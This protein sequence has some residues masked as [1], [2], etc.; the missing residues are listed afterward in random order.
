MDICRISKAAVSYDIVI[1]GGGPA[2]MAA[3]VAAR[4]QGIKKTLRH[5]E[6]VYSQ[7]FWA[8]HFWRRADGA[9]ICGTLPG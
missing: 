6:P 3:A 1:I 5:P 4:E 2:G 9:G 7:R 8:S